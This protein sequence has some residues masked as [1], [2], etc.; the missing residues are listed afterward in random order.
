MRK[1]AVLNA[2]QVR[3]AEREVQMEVD[4][5]VQCR[6]GIV[7]A[8]DDVCGAGQQAGAYPHEQLDEKRFLIGEVAIDRRS[9]DTGGGTDVL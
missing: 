8:G 6:P 4:Q 5:S 1:V 7:G 9:A 2:D 3:L